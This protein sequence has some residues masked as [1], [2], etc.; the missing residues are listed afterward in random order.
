[1]LI[2]ELNLKSPYSVKSPQSEGLFLQYSNA[3]LQQ[4]VQCHIK[5]SRE[6]LGKQ[7]TVQGMM[8]PVSGLT[9]TTL[10]NIFL[11]H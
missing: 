1:M 4:H 5:G 2:M 8:E 3:I 11:T 6:I 9:H 7:W 10:K